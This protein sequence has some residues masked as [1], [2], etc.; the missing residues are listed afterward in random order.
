[1]LHKNRVFEKIGDWHS[2]GRAM[3]LAC[4]IATE[5]STYSKPGDFIVIADNGDYQGLVSGGCVEGDLAERARQALSSQRV[6]LVDYDLGGEHDALWGMGAGCDGSLHIVLIPICHAADVDTLLAL[7]SAYMAGHA[8]VLAVRRQDD[9]SALNLAMIADGDTRPT[10]R[11]I[12]SLLPQ[13]T[14]QLLAKLGAAAPVASVAGEWFVMPVATAPRVLLCGAAP[15]A[16]P[17]CG[18]LAQ[19][20]WSTSVYDHRPAYVEALPEPEVSQSFCAPAAALAT[21]VELSRFDAVVIMSH[22]LASDEH[23]LKAVAAESHWDYIGVLG[24]HHR[25]ARL[26]DS[27]GGVSAEVLA[28]MHGPAGLDIG[29]REPASIALS[30]VAQMQAVLSERGRL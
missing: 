28:R 17:L 22:H 20:G 6:V 15:D 19:L 21:T 7:R 11:S 29:A 26:I 1:M 2:Q 27:I 12:S 25:R 18:L 14:G 9:D 13:L 5:G 30:I 4:V 8:S 23:Y 10:P 16:H 24:P 3:V